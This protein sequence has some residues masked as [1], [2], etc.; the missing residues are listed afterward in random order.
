MPPSL[1]DQQGVAVLQVLPGTSGGLL[2]DW[3]GHGR[4]A[5]KPFSPSKP[6][7]L[8]SE[9]LCADVASLLGLPIPARQVV[10]FDGERYFGLEW[11]D[12]GNSF[13]P[14]M[15]A[16]LVNPD[17]I[18]GMLA[19]DVLV[20]NRDRHA[21]NVLFQR[22][23]PTLDKYSCVLI[24][25]SHA[26]IGPL[27]SFAAFQTFLASNPDPDS[28]LRGTPSQLR[29]LVNNLDVFDPWIRRIEGLSVSQLSDSLARIPPEWVPSGNDCRDLLDF[30]VLRKNR[31]RTLVRSA[32]SNFPSLQSG[33]GP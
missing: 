27:Q 19:F 8:V 21:G 25:H 15:E 11:R 26:L 1:F 30:L 29:A 14:G 16:K 18:P 20:C 22:P 23:S 17:V 13:S 5:S 33:G 7:T 24:D 9:W 6:F 32:V 31:V 28:F 2:L 4:Y 3:L 10:P 12:D